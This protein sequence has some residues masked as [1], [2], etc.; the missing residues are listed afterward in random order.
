MVEPRGPARRRRPV[1]SVDPDVDLH[2][3]QQRGELRGRGWP[4]LVVIAG[5]GVLGAL[6]R[7]ALATH[8]ATL[9]GF[10]TAT[11]FVNVLGSALIGVLMT[12]ITTC[13]VHRLVRPF[14]GVGV[15]GG[16]TTF[17]AY[18]VDVA[19]LVEGGQAGVALATFVVTPI[20]ALAAVWVG[21]RGTAAALGRNR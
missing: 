19:R 10:P 14:L 1:G 11:V 3:P 12:V 5:G 2:D 13:G 15:L 8:D 20:A 6:A 17:S 21:A 4:V 9:S 7:A 16:F 18:A